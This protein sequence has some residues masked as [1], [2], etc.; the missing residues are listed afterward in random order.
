MYHGP[1]LNGASLGKAS[2]SM[3]AD[4]HDRR[5]G[6]MRRL[7]PLVLFASLAHP[8][9]ARNIYQAFSDSKAE[10]VKEMEH[11]RISNNMGTMIP[12]FSNLIVEDRA[13][14]GEDLLPYGIAANRNALELILRY[15]Y[16]Q[17]ITDRKFAIEDIFHPELLNT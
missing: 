6:P 10:A 12:W 2:C 5:K 7:A 11:Q 15:H 8:S 4:I 13:L 9:L 17:G 3:A 1:Y 14:M 16:E